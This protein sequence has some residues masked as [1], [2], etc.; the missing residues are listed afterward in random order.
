MVINL[1]V[2]L[3]VEHLLTTTH[4]NNNN[5]QTWKLRLPLSATECITVTNLVCHS[6]TKVPLVCK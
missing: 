6:I 4:N 3:K 1:F 5:K 2:N